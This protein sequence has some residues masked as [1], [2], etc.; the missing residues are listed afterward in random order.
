VIAITQNSRPLT[1]R[2]RHRHSG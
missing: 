2:G 1:S